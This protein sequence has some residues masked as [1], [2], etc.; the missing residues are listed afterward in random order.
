MLSNKVDDDPT[1][2]MAILTPANGCPST[3]T[4]PEMPAD[5]RPASVRA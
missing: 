5:A 3:R 4:F 1:L 2:L